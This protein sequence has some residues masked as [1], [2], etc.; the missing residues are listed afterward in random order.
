MEFELIT[1]NS[2]FVEY[3]A[4]KIWLRSGGL[5]VFVEIVTTTISSPLPHRSRQHQQNIFHQILTFQNG[6]PWINHSNIQPKRQQQQQQT[7]WQICVLLKHFVAFKHIIFSSQLCVCVLKYLLL[8]TFIKM[9]MELPKMPKIY[10]KKL[11]TVHKRMKPN[12]ECLRKFFVCI[13]NLLLLLLLLLWFLVFI[14]T[15]R[16]RQHINEKLW[17]THQCLSK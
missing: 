2:L 10:A 6:L 11:M 12:I 17:N 15:Q 5:I 14:C 13:R 9:R 16:G 4:G 8:L 7:K 3:K 1:M